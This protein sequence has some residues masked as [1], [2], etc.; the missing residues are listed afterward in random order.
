MKDLIEYYPNSC[1]VIDN[2]TPMTRIYD[3]YMEDVKK[4]FNGK[5]SK[6]DVEIGKLISY[7]QPLLKVNEIIMRLY[8]TLVYV[9][10]QERLRRKHG[11]TYET[12]PN[13]DKSG[14]IREDVYKLILSM[15]KF[16]DVLS[17][18]YI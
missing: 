11:Y 12:D 6:K 9:Y 4:E 18:E 5:L 14:G 17:E 2:K 15:F 1:K 8:E 7:V 3:S 16:G 10:L 13:R